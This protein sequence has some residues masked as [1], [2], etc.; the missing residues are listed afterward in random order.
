M[1]KI[2]EKKVRA[3]SLTETMVVVAILA[4]VTTGAFVML[5]S[6]QAT[7]FTID[8]QIGLQDNLRQT[9]NKISRELNQSGFDQSATAQYTVSDAAGVN[10]S[11]IIKFS[12]PVICH[13]NDNFLDAN[14]NIAHWGAP[15][16]WGCAD[17]TCMDADN[18][19]ATVDYKFIQYSINTNNQL[20]RKVLDPVGTVKRQDILAQD[21]VDLQITVSA[22]KNVLT[23]TITA[24]R[25][26]ALNRTLTSSTTFAVYLRNRG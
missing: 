22:D 9:A 19:C 4:V 26:S 14:S 1:I 12:I 17:Y 5:S 23:M 21:I 25:K 8:T 6:G 7:W 13:Q 3:F 20:V 15:L 24:R 2:F 11:D 18:N 10:A 16:T